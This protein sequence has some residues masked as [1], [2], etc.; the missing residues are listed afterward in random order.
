MII[1]FENSENHI[2]ERIYSVLEEER[3]EQMPFEM[4][5]KIK[6]N[7]LEIDQRKQRV[8]LKNKEVPLNH[9]EYQTLLYLASHPK[10]IFSKEQIYQA[11][12][13]APGELCGSA[14]A[15]VISQIRRKLRQA[16]VERDY[17]QT[18]V[19]SGYRFVCEEAMD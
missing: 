11:V 16:G 7:D 15:N 6:F 5:E 2:M 10:W 14:V 13:K 4:S 9:Y 8:L 12:W 17:I 1:A 3:F 18:I 19:N